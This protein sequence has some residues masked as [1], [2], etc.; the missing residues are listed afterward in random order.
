MIS[1][2]LVGAAVAIAAILGFTPVSVAA[3]QSGVAKMQRNGAVKIAGRD[4]RCGSTRNV[5]D[6]RLPSEGAAAPGVL[7]INPRLI[8]RMPQT[9]RLFIYYHECGHHNIGA[10]EL[11]ADAWAVERGVR[12]GWLDKA[13]LR[14]VCRSFGN[15]PATRTHPS[16]RS[17]CRNLDRTYERAMARQPKKAPAE[18][19]AAAAG[20]KPKL[21]SGPRV[22]GTGKT[23]VDEDRAAAAKR[24]EAPARAVR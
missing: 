20:D 2:R 16:G 7:I 4:L 6:G 10:S 8:A 9:V 24:S 15:M 11:R 22:I 1:M 19:A 13:G 17:R 18:E 23:A 3:P 12:E 14:Q 21:I 5:L